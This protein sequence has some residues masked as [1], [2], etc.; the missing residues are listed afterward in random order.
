MNK[1]QCGQWTVPGAAGEQ[2]FQCGRLHFALGHSVSE[3]ATNH[4][5]TASQNSHDHASR[6]YLLTPPLPLVSSLHTHTGPAAN[7]LMGV[8]PTA[9]M[10]G[11]RETFFPGEM[12]FPRFTAT[13]GERVGGA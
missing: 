6:H 4:V 7:L 2:K 9:Y 5:C 13:L 8:V 3:T 11:S 12:N 10:R 1:G